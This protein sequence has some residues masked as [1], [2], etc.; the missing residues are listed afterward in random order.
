MTEQPRAAFKSDNAPMVS[1]PTNL[2]VGIWQKVLRLRCPICGMGRIFKKFID[3]APA[4]EVCGYVYE[5]EQGYFLVAMV[6]NYGVTVLAVMAGWIVLEF[7]LKASS[8]RLGWGLAIIA[9]AFPICFYPYSKAL[10]MAIDVLVDPP[11]TQDFAKSREP[12]IQSS[13]TEWSDPKS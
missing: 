5:R 11:K 9:I 6:I 10:W 13:G 2:K 1:I 4:C 7:V 8:V 12:Q 3:M